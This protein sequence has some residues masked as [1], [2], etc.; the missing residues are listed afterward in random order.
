MSMYPDEGAL[1]MFLYDTFRKNLSEIVQGESLEYT[2]HKVIQW[3]EGRSRVGKLVEALIEEFPERKELCEILEAIPEK[4]RSAVAQKT[5][6][7]EHVQIDDLHVQSPYRREA[8]TDPVK[9]ET[10]TPKTLYEVTL[11]GIFEETDK[12]KLEALVVHF[13]GLSGDVSLIL[14]K[15]SSGSIKLVFEGSEEGLKQLKAL[16]ESG[17]L[18]QAL[19][20][21]VEEIRELEDQEILSLTA[22]RM[23]GSLREKLSLF[24]EPD[25]EETISSQ[26][27]SM[28]VVVETKE[29]QPFNRKKEVGG[30]SC[31]LAPRLREGTKKAHT[32]A[33]NVGFVKCF[34]RGV[35]E[36]NSYRKLVANLYFVYS[37]MEEELERH[38]EHPILSNLYFT[39]LNRKASLEKDLQ[40]YFGTGWRE[41]VAPSEAAQT[42]VARIRELS[43]TDPVLL[44]GHGYTRYLGDL[45]GGQILKKIAIRGMDLND[46]EGTAFYEFEDISDEKA[47]KNAYRQAMNDLPLDEETVERIVDEANYAFKLNMEMFKELE[48]NLI[49]AIGKML[50]NTL[51]SRRCNC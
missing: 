38:R 22:Q 19:G 4:E 30:R 2:A 32:M 18:Q 9:S 7:L 3:A 8:V 24:D 47:F 51:T 45:S 44:L 46:G 14:K 23:E 16:I 13:I 35:V 50:Y 27:E 29:K 31:F 28:T 11:T 10:A 21:P 36:K 37:A 12:K 15:I 42:Y 40:F 1:E 49:Q 41:R 25:S 39:E 26:P 6:E 5:R 33:E 34:L 17:D 48:G 43:E 20:F